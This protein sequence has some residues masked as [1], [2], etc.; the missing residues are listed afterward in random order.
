V[1]QIGAFL[2]LVRIE[3]L[4]IAV[5]GVTF[6]YCFI[7]IP[8]HRDYNLLHTTLLPFTTFE[9]VLFALSIALV[10]AAGNIINDYCDYEADREFKTNR[11]L[12]QNFFSLDTALY[13]HAAFAFAGIGIGFYL[14][15]SCGNYKIGYLYVICVVLLYVYSAYLKKVPLA[16]NIL[17]SALAGFVF[18][19]LLVF[20]ANFL[21]TITFEQ[22]GVTFR[23]LYS[24]AIFYGAFAF[25]T[26][27]AREIV[28]DIEDREGDAT[29]EVNTLA[30]AYGETTAKYIAVTVL[31][32]LLGGLGY[33]MQGFMK[34]EAYKQFSYL[35][36]AVVLPTLVA[37]AFLV[38]CK[39][40]K[41]YHRV[42]TMI[43]LIM[44]M[45]LLSI[46]VFYLFNLNGLNH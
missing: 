20:E 31:L 38:K 43:K 36:L 46:P 15:Y 3:N 11:P 22:S 6:F 26:N 10:A 35:L 12:A 32:L 33:Y 28:K 1:K 34:A 27:L 25:V 37:I 44:I 29:F 21:N 40:Q 14:G 24:A 2:R 45:G 30:V 18:F 4:L 19:L 8:R 23:I 41:D 13:L 5:A 9:F 39:T 17:V 16:G 42:S 7:L